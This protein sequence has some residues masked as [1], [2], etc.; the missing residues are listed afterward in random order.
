MLI[1]AL[2]LG[3]NKS[4]VCLYQSETGEHSF[5]K[6]ATTPQALHDLLVEVEPQ[7]VVF[8][9][10]AAAGWLADLCR[11]LGLEFQVANANHEAWR[12]K[13]VKSKTDRKDAVKLAQLSAM[14]Q[15]PTVYLPRKAVRQWRS[16]IGYRQGL[17]QRRTAIKN[18]LRS[19]LDREGLSWPSGRKGWSRV[20]LKELAHLA[21]PLSACEAEE[22]WRGEVDQELQQLV[23]IQARI[24][25]VEAKLD[26]LAA[27]DRRVQLLQTAGGVGPR[28]AETIVATIDDPHRFKTGKQIGCYAGLTPRQFQSGQMDRQGRISKQ[29]SRLL[30]TLLIEVS[31]AALRW[32]AWAK[33]T[34]QRISRDNPKNRSKAIVALARRI[35][36]RCW[37]MLRDETVWRDQP[38]RVAQGSP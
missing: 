30:R 15:L 38:P 27:G 36:V 9:A 20:Q 31:W 6:V 34:F 3:K 33:A 17:I 16:L 37:A 18:H 25:E 28:L 22:L 29:G 24:G 2:D 5:R 35:L 12:W 4:V 21:R 8:E 1:L 19:V 13:N 26:A 23:M 10:G 11:V 14:N 32:N 7:R